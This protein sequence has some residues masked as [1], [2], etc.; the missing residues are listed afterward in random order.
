MLGLIANNFVRIYHPVSVHP[1]AASRRHGQG[2]CHKNWRPKAPRSLISNIKIEAAILAIKHSF[3]VDNYNCGASLGTLSVK[4][5]IAQKY[6]GAVGTSGNGSTG[7]MKNYNYDERL[8]ND[9]ASELHRAAQ[10][11]LGDRP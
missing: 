6:R 1:Q 11:G 3:I 5:A 10:V 2:E 9:R 7:Y 8:E 4:G